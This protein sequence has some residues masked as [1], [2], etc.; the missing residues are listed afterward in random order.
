MARI[1]FG[2]NRI[3]FIGKRWVYK[4]P[5]F[6]R[7]IRANKCEYKNYLK[8]SDIVAETHKKWYGLKQEKLTD[9]KIF[10]RWATIEE[11]PKELHF[12][13]KRKINNRMQVGKSN[14]VWKFFDYEDVKFFKN[15][16]KACNN[17]HI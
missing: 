9:T 3:V 2:T 4:I 16:S 10:E 13:Y 6:Y 1:K 5:I 7:G 17:L 8:N 15:E 12:L 14:N 11:I